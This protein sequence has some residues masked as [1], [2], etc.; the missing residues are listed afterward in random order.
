M[1]DSRVK[2]KNLSET[3]TV[4]TSHGIGLKKVLLSNE[5]TISNLT[6]IAVTVLRKGEQVKTHVHET[7]DEHYLFWEG[8]GRFV[9]GNRKI[10]CKPGVF[11]LVPAGVSHSMIAETDMKFITIGVAL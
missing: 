11:L 4:S 2:I 8:E 3:R 10:R 9:I 5:E 7:M 6:Q 1:A